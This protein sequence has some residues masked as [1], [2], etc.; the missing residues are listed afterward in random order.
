MRTRNIPTT[1]LSPCLD[2]TLFTHEVACPGFGCQPSSTLGPFSCPSSFSLV[3][4]GTARREEEFALDK[5]RETR[6]PL[7]PGWIMDD[8]FTKLPSSTISDEPPSHAV[9]LTGIYFYPWHNPFTLFSYNPQ[10]KAKIIR[11]TDTLT[12]IVWH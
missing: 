5:R 2:L 1:V 8:G 11:H 7:E 9:S 10:A 3:H 12:L 6:D 4:L